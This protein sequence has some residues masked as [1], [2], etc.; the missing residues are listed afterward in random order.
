[1]G[2]LKSYQALFLQSRALQPC[3]I[4]SLEDHSF[5]RIATN[6]ENMFYI[7]FDVVYMLIPKS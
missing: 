3:D 7:H 5:Y 2:P 1:M 4:S 6:R